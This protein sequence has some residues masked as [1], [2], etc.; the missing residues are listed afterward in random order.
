VSFDPCMDGSSIRSRIGPGLKEIIF[1]PSPPAPRFPATSCRLE[2]GVCNGSVIQDLA[3]AD[4]VTFYLIMSL[5]KIVIGHSDGAEKSN[6]G[7]G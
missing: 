6:E 3:T 7:D 1:D 2:L 5:A 4:I